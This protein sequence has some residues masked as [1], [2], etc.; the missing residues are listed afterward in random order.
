MPNKIPKVIHYCWF[1]GSPLPKL[2]IKCINSW[3]KYMPDYKIIE[4]NESNFDITSCN[5][6]EEAYRKQKWAFVSDYVRFKVL[7]KYGGIYFDTDVEIIKPLEDLLEDGSFIACEAPLEGENIKIAPGLGFGTIPGQMM[8]KKILT[9]YENSKFDGEHGNPMTVVERTTKIFIKSG[10]DSSSAKIQNINGFTIYPPEYFCPYNYWSGKLV[11]TSNTRAIHHYSESWHSG[12]EKF[13]M[14]VRRFL[15]KRNLDYTVI[16]RVT[17]Y[18]LLFIEKIRIYGFREAIRLIKK[19][20][21][22][23]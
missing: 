15:K 11:I 1:G 14:K 9:S 4:W 5:Y 7:Y 10:Y 17:L 18:P 13:N 21:K 19:R 8:I 3:K 20:M 6:V 22:W 23:E 16:G 12:I 2:A